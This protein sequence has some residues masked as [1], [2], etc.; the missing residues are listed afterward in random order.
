MKIHLLAVGIRM[1]DW[2]KTGYAEYAGRLPRECQLNLIE[3]PAGKRSTRADLPRLVRAEGERL[4]AAIPASSRVIALDERGREWGTA[5]LAGQLAGWLQEGCN[6][7]LLI[8]GPD[9]LDAACRDRAEHLWSLSRLTLPHPLVRIVVAE[10]LYRAW[11]LLHNH[12][13][14]RA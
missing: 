12:P 11:S 2:I 8:G 9:G 3:I 7:S 4:L 6:L 1:P 10:Q 5:E 14:H 13:Y